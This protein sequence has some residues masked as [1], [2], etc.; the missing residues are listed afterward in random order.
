MR[1]A[2]PVVAIFDRSAVASGFS[3]L[4]EN[5]EGK[6]KPERSGRRSKGAMDASAEQHATAAAERSESALV[7]RARGGDAKAFRSLV[8]QHAA[9]AVAVALRLVRSADDAEEVAQDAFVRV[10]RALPSFRGEAA[11]STWL[12]RI[13]VRCALDRAA[14]LRSRGRREVDESVETVESLHPAD[15]GTS[16]TASTH[17]QDEMERLVAALPEPQRVAITLYYYQDQSVDEVALSLEMNVNTVKTHLRR[18]RLAL[19]TA[20]LRKTER[21]GG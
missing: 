9:R 2:P 7:E 11:F 8:D 16:S 6:L 21:A 19:R 14:A 3:D 13:V 5:P 12:H 15:S 1:P 17:S 20:W 4:P 18:A 10:W